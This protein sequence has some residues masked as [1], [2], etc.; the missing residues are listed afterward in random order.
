MAGCSL[1]STK[2]IRSLVF[3]KQLLYM[4]IDI[5]IDHVL[6][7]L[8]CCVLLVP[9]EWSFVDGLS[10]RHYLFNHVLEFLITFL[11]IFNLRLVFLLFIVIVIFKEWSMLR[12]ISYD[13]VISRC[14][15][16]LFRFRDREVRLLLIERQVLVCEIEDVLLMVVLF[17]YIFLG[18][19]LPYGTLFLLLKNILYHLDII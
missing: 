18:R 5:F 13:R 16:C 9:L 8:G 4:K 1:L 11:V 14:S 17:V 7:I 6:D 3:G 15:R 12:S 2:V 19:H 10:I